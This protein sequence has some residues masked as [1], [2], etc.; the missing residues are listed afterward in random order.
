MPRTDRAKLDPGIFI[1]C[2]AAWAVFA[3]LSLLLVVLL[4]T[5]HP[6]NENYSNRVI[7]CLLVCLVSISGLGGSLTGLVMTLLG[8]VLDSSRSSRKIFDET[9]SAMKGKPGGAPLS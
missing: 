9:D 7:G 3:F 6:V 4:V 1:A 2:T 5:F 8:R